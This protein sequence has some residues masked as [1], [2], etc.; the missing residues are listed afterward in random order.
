MK[1]RYLILKMT[2]ELEKLDFESALNKLQ[3]IVSSLEND[4]ITLDKSIELYE[5]GVILKE[6]CN[7]RLEKA[8]MKVQNIDNK[9][10]QND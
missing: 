3:E 10:Q 7:K 6:I 4:S 2:K 5:Q 8:K 1:L 9:K